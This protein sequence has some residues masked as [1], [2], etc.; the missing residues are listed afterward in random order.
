MS[1]VQ[2]DLDNQIKEAMAAIEAKKT[3]SEVREVSKSTETPNKGSET[4]DQIKDDVTEKALKMGWKP[5]GKKDAQRFVE[6]QSFFD[7][8]DSKNKKIDELADTVRSLVEH[9]TKLEKATYEKA[10]RD[11]QAAKNEAVSQ[12]D[13]QR[14]QAIEKEQIQVQ[15]QIYEAEQHAEAI[16]PKVE[17]T[18]ITEELLSFKSRNEDWFNYNTPENKDM[19]EDAD[20][21]DKRI[22]K[23][24]QRA[25]KSLTQKEHLELV[26][27]AIKKQ[28]PHRFK[29]EKRD[30][31]SM[32]ETSTTSRESN[33]SD[34]S[35]KLT[36][37][38]REIVRQA[39]RVGSKM[40]EESY[41]KQLKL[42]GELR[43]E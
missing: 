19:V 33:K 15:K 2:E 3:T 5:G 1:E 16:K 43:D 14:Y 41:A 32:V 23:Q 20:Y 34:L 22:A 9:N 8:I 38:Q 25:G 29:N 4:V 36:K 30:T 24:A 13:I 21:I 26:E 17:Q 40:T 18:P 10:M 28:Y 12:A 35:S 31:G 11:L 37:Q 39:R 7:K 42:T 6:D 27:E